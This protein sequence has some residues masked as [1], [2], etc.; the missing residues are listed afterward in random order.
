MTR[1]LLVK[2][3]DTDDGFS[4]AELDEMMARWLAA[5]EEAEQIGDWA[6]TLGRHYTD[7]AEYTWNLG[8]DED[9]VARGLQQIKEWALGVQMEGFEGWQYPYDKILIDEVQGEV[10]AFWRQIA[11]VKRK[12]GSNYEVVGTGGSW[13]KYGG[14]YKWSAQHD[15]FDFGNVM[16]LFA[17]LAADGHLHPAVKAKISTLARGGRLAGHVKRA[18][19]RSTP[20]KAR[21]F[22]ALARIAALGR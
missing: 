5:N 17:E 13:F 16:A 3:K 2:S 12:D 11:P 22:L 14:D 21:G 10:V 18:D 20:Q 6:G 9:F 4:R 8:A 7:D 1:G 15:F 19:R